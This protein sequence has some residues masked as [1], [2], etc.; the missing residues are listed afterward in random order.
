MKR[1]LVFFLA[2]CML[3]ISSFGRG[4]AETGAA[5]H[6]YLPVV[7]DNFPPPPQPELSGLPAGGGITLGEAVRMTFTG[8]NAVTPI[9]GQARAG[10]GYDNALVVSFPGL[11][12][13]SDGSRIAVVA[14]DFVTTTVAWAGGYWRVVAE[15]NEWLAGTPYSLTLDVRPV[16]TGTFSVL[17]KVVM[18]SQDTA[19]LPY[20]N[21]W[22]GQTITEADV[23][24]VSPPVGASG[25]DAD[26]ENATLVT[27]TVGLSA[28]WER[29]AA[30]RQSAGVPAL[31][32]N[33]AYAADCQ[34][35][36]AYMV[37]NDVLTHT[38][39]TGD[40]GYT[41]GGYAAGQAGAL[42]GFAY[43]GGDYQEVWAADVLMSDPFTAMQVLNPWLRWSGAGTAADTSGALR[44][45][46][47]LDIA[48]GVDYLATPGYPV[49]WPP[50]GG[51]TP[52]LAYQGGAAPD[53]LAS[54]GFSAP[55]G[56][57]VVF[58]LG[59]GAT[60]PQ[61][62]AS[63]FSENGAARP[64]CIYTEG[65]YTNPDPAAQ[66]AGRDILN[67]FDAV[68][69]VPQYPLQ[70]GQTYQASITVAGHTYSTSFRAR[71]A[72][73]AYPVGMIR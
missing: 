21:P 72:Y 71:D 1:I 25:V 48:R 30:F 27:Y 24:L 44:Q 46:G 15:N 13:A 31:Q 23:R 62:S 65:T 66:Q 63:S 52:V 53:P 41:V 33:A 50:D 20:T 6:A 14:S 54:C 64:Y 70:P 68:V 26:G 58:I 42:A 2:A 69:L 59:D 43:T 36:A 17:S 19:N 18:H 22:S 39:R 29:I 56:P 49:V 73:S 9:P 61:V 12:R 11:T 28:M 38:E 40:P 51:D 8:R 57:P 67:A 7:L 35:H 34:A 10:I 60:S 45:A 4:R 47:C 32:Y 37:T 16:M 3:W 5:Y 55:S